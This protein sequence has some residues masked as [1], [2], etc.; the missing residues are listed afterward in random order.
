MNSYQCH[1]TVLGIDKNATL[2]DI[3]K[4]YKK[5][6][7]QYHPDKNGGDSQLFKRINEAYQI[8]SDP[9]KR[10][11]Y[12]NSLN[13]FKNSPFNQHI[14]IDF[15]NVVLK[16]AKE[17]IAARRAQAQSHHEEKGKTN[18]D[19]NNEKPEKHE[20]PDKNGSPTIVKLKVPLEDLYYGKAK[21]VVIKVRND[22]N[23]TSK[24]FYIS[25][26]NYE[27]TY[28]FDG[29]GDNGGNLIVNIDVIPHKSGIQIDK[30]ICQY[31][32]YIE[33]E[34][35]LYEYYYGIEYNIIH[36]DGKVLTCQKTFQDG[37]MIHVF[38]QKGLPQ[39]NLDE[40]KVIR[41]DFYVFFKLVMKAH[42]V[43]PLNNEAFREWMLNFSD[44]SNG[45]QE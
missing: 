31:D 19:V 18:E 26:L 11:D 44:N 39:Y 21:K 4:A 12:D 8:L 41:G 23:V 6:A 5:L 14:I 16:V 36:I 27:K 32:L 3:K 33:R 28:V 10:Q 20:A 40:D 45:T 25:L 42:N 35:N 9:T 1:Y 29:Q 37:S 17:T 43:L 22:G 34:I 7:L 15:V 30:I 2:E 24:P 13:G 38:K